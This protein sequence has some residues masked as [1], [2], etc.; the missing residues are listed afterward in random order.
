MWNSVLGCDFGMCV[1][2]S[3]PQLFFLRKFSDSLAGLNWEIVNFTLKNSSN[4]AAKTILTKT[5]LQL[6]NNC[7]F[8]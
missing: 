6:S 4:A 3:L 1:S 8:S 7:C 2:S 5:V